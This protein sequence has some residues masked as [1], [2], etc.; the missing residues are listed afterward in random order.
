M[1]ENKDQVGA[2]EY[3]QWNDQIQINPEEKIVCGIYI[4]RQHVNANK[5]FG[6]H[7]K[8]QVLKTH[9]G[10]GYDNYM[11]VRI[12][13]SSA[14]IGFILK[15]ALFALTSKAKHWREIR[16]TQPTRTWE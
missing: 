14:I 16:I 3:K 2:L 12:A 7:V 8:E 10:G 6:W 1:N 9:T 11:W 15:R 4:E 5:P 13:F